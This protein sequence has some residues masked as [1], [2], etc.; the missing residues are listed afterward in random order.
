MFRRLQSGDT[1][2]CNPA[3]QSE[4]F[5]PAPPKATPLP[6]PKSDGKLQYKAFERGIQLFQKRNFRDAREMFQHTLEGQALETQG[7]TGFKELGMRVPS[8]RFGAG[9]RLLGEGCKTR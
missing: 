1:A 2:G 3:L 4:G 7:V 6:E 8:L 9:E 5:C